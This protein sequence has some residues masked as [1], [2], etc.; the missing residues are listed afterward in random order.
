MIKR[1]WEKER[2]REGEAEMRAYPDMS[3]CKVRFVSVVFHKTAI[4]RSEID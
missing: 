4:S 3:P 2:E 1:V